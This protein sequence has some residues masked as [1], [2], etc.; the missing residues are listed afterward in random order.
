MTTRS[1]VQYTLS[2]LE[3]P[4]SCHTDSLYIAMP[5]TDGSW[6]DWQAQYAVACNFQSF[7]ARQNIF[8]RIAEFSGWQ[9]LALAFVE[10]K[11]V[12]HNWIWC[13]GLCSVKKFVRS[14]LNDGQVHT[15][16][17]QFMTSNLKPNNCNQCNYAF[18]WAKYI[19]K[20]TWGHWWHHY[21]SVT[22]RPP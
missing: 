12:I 10:S 16:S 9:V 21:T 7:F 22:V 4:P 5:G 13:S 15:L 11:E 19:K 2:V 1:T 14:D 3:C 17:P 18:T 20:R 6:V 8:Q